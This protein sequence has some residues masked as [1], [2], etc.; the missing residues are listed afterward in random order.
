MEARAFDDPAVESVFAGYSE[1]VRSRLLALRELILDTADETDGVGRVEETL[2]WGQPS[3]LT[4]QTRSGSTIRM[5]AVQ[6]VP[7]G[8]ALYFICNTNL[9]ETFREIYP[10]D[11]RYGGNRVIRLN[12]SEPIAE[13]PLRHCIALALTYH[14]RKRLR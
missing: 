7:G 6:D 8:Y 1:P 10:T 2:K 13:A 5:D 11:F 12:V 4:P 9:V 14:K 3:Y